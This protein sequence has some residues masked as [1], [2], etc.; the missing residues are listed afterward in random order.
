MHMH[1]EKLSPHTHKSKSTETQQ[2]CVFLVTQNE[3]AVLRV[4]LFITEGEHSVG[5]QLALP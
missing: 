2:L 3:F 5:C 1:T 4:T